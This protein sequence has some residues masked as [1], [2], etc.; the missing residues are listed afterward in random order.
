MCCL[1]QIRVEPCVVC[2][3][4]ISH[5]WHVRRRLSLKQSIRRD[6]G[7]FGLLADAGSHSHAERKVTS[8][9]LPSTTRCV[10]VA[11]KIR[12]TEFIREERIGIRL[13]GNLCLQGARPLLVT[14]ESH[15]VR[16]H[17]DRVVY[18]ESDKNH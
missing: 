3:Q 13:R 9:G 1:F 6:Q 14:K 7:H 17:F 10:G 15:Y 11:G 4:T 8:A 18:Y 5:K 12:A 16:V 2:I